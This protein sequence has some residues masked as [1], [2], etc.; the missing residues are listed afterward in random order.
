[1]TRLSSLYG[2]GSLAALEE[3]TE[4]ETWLLEA[5]YEIAERRIAASDPDEFIYPPS[6]ASPKTLK[7]ASSSITV[8]DWRG[9]F[10]KV[11]A[12]LVFV[13]AFKILD[14]LIEWVLVENGVAPTRKAY[15]FA[16]K[17]DALKGPLQFPRLIEARPW[18]RERLC[19]LYEQL[20][21][22][23]GTIIHDRRF[24]SASGT[25]EVSSTKRGVIGPTVL[26][27]EADR[28]NL[29]VIFVSILRY[30]QGIW[31]MDAFEEKCLRRALDELTHLHGLET[32]GQLPPQRL[33]VQLCVLDA[34]PI[35]L[36]LPRIR[37]DI[38][39]KFP[40]QDTVFDVQVTVVS[41]SEA[42][43]SAYLISW[44]ELSQIQG[45]FT[46]SQLDLAPCVIAIPAD[47][48][49]SEVAVELDKQLGEH[50]K[51]QP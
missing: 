8:G 49:P 22:L 2:A 18:L 48:D 10:L 44:D 31:T 35:K 26:I 14:M 38:A 15:T 13:T 43:A 36:D 21:P 24:T 45:V 40:K 3:H 23:R 27:T 46:R 30:L 9:G 42:R 20:E 28:R 25:L 6:G 12:P 11:G 29:T 50:S 5:V 41:R 16:E 17:I 39:A 32:L 34:D 7:Y 33:E 37:V 1:M 47:L 51:S 4:Y 19:G